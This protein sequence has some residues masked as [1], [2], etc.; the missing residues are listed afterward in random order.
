MGFNA[1]HV[2]G[3]LPEQLDALGAEY[4]LVKEDASHVPAGAVQTLDQSKA[5]RVAAKKGVL[6]REDA[7]RILLGPALLDADVAALHET[8]GGQAFA[9]R[10]GIETIGLGRGAV[11]E[12]HQGPARGDR[13][14]CAN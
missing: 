2:W 1:G 11:E 8:G 9:E 10:I 14:L 7:V 3:N 13:L 4:I 6:A 12:A 5:H